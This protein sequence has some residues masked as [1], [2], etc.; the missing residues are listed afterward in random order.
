MWLI[1]FR[2]PFF[3][4]S[5]KCQQASESALKFHQFFLAWW[6]FCYIFSSLHQF[7]KSY[8]SRMHLVFSWNDNDKARN[9]YVYFLVYQTIHRQQ[10][11]RNGKCGY[12]WKGKGRGGIISNCNYAWDWRVQPKWSKYVV[13]SLETAKIILLEQS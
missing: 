9:S 8:V 3:G 10:E 6:F 5:A 1:A 13:K 4:L 2:C 12:K 11:I 7:Y